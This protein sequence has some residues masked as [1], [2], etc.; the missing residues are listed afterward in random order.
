MGTSAAAILGF[1]LVPLYT[2]NLSPASYGLLE[3]LNVTGQVV[4][5]DG[6]LT[7]AT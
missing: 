1:I 6:G 2:H 7:L 5:V 3:L 4:V